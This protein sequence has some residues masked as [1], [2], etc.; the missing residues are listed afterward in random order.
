VHDRGD[1]RGPIPSAAAAP[2]EDPLART[3]AAAARAEAVLRTVVDRAPL[4]FGLLDRDLRYLLVNDALAEI[5]GLPAAEHVGRSLHA[6]VPA[7]ADATTTL[8]KGVLA[9]GRPVIDVEQE[10]ETPADPGCRRVWRVS[11]Y[12]IQS[13]HAVEGVAIIVREVTE[14]RRQEQRLRRI[15]DGLFAF[16]ALVTPEGMV[17]ELNR[18]ALEI[19]GLTLDEVRQRPVWDAPWWGDDPAV[20][21]RARK[22]VTRAAGGEVVRYEDQVEVPGARLTLELQVVPLVEDGKVAA[23]VASALDVTE[24]RASSR[25]AQLIARLARRLTSARTSQEAARIISEYGAPV[26]GA[27]YAMIGIID[28]NRGV[29]QL[30]PSVAL[31]PDIARHERSLPLDSATGMAHTARTGATVFLPDDRARARLYPETVD[32]AQR[33]GVGASLTAPLLRADGSIFG[34]LGFVWR[35]PLDAE[36]APSTTIETIADVCAQ[37]L[38]RARQGDAARHLLTSLQRELLPVTPEVEHLDLAVRYRPA[39][40]ELEFGGDWY[41]IVTLDRHRTAVIVGDIAGHGV[42]AAARM[43]QV[44]TVLSAVVRLDDDLDGLFERVEQLTERNT[45]NRFATVSVVVVDTASGTLRAV[46]AG[47]LPPVLVEPGGDV[48][49]L[50]PARRPLLGV[51]GGRVRSVP[52]P[53]E[54]G[55]VLVSFTDGLVERPGENLDHGLERLRR[56][57]SGHTGASSGDLADSLL[58]ELLDAHPADDVALA[59]VRR[60]R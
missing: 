11:Y 43:A 40:R 34:V 46:S 50:E 7:L 53:F 29:V 51:A 39:G 4:G 21:Q 10:G 38:D 41:D 59:V 8:I 18:P 45:R 13:P 15:M 44:R 32:A 20:R 54:P 37:T 27:E 55:A 9:T 42:A 25:R 36:P 60:L 33:F 47:H 5:N 12:R 49:L 19:S 35:E 24:Q 23:L 16:V 2:E 48:R 57:V 52:E 58:V 56:A 14:Q 26:V 28:R 3:A 1:D 31:P 17:T 22:A 6:V 30:L